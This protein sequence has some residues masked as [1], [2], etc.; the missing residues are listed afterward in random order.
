MKFLRI[1]LTIFVVSVFS[2]NLFAEMQIDIEVK[3][4]EKRKIPICL[5]KFK[6]IDKSGKINKINDEVFQTIIKDLTFSP[7][8]V[9]FFTSSLKIS[10][11]DILGKPNSLANTSACVPFP[12]PGAPNKINLIISNAFL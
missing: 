5:I 11:K 3:A 9:L 4:K 2:I 6:T 1:F 10:P 7:K 12:L 8:L